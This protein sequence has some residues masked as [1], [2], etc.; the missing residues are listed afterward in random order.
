MLKCF[1]VQNWLLLM[2]LA[3]KIFQTNMR[4]RGLLEIARP[5]TKFINGKVA[6]CRSFL[7]VR[8]FSGSSLPSTLQEMNSQQN[9]GEFE[10][11]NVLDMVRKSTWCL[12][13]CD[14]SGMCHSIL[15]QGTLVHSCFQTIILQQ[16]SKTVT[17]ETRCG[18]VHARGQDVH[19]DSG[20]GPSS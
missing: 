13:T 9:H 11:T 5:Q 7:F 1:C 10:E 6:L 15:N 19:I 3:L 14:I 2:I 8:H 4:M 17:A 18:Q 16:S 20:Q 12:Q